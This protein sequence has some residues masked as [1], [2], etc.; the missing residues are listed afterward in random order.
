[1][2]TLYE[3]AFCTVVASSGRNPHD[4]MFTSRDPLRYSPCRIPVPRSGIWY[5]YRERDDGGPETA[6]ESHLNSRAWVYQEIILSRRMLYFTA[7]V[8][9]WSCRHGESC[10]RDSLGETCFDETIYISSGSAGYHASNLESAHQ[11]I[12][13]RQPPSGETVWGFG[14]GTKPWAGSIVNTQICRKF[15][16]DMHSIHA[17]PTLAQTESHE[18]NK[19]WFELVAEYTCRSLTVPG[20]KLIALSAIAT[21]LAKLWKYTHAA[22]LWK[23][24]LPHGLVWY[25]MY[26]HD[27]PQ[28]Y[29]ALS[30]SW[31]SIHG[32]VIFDDDSYNPTR[33][34]FL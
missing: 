20:D 13:G 5:A 34:A 7:F 17:I 21:K 8:V 31:A 29:I 30:F 16:N 15:L 11:G 32:E 28:N 33:T 10:E 24:T 1:M 9:F 27:R 3:N 23:E 2:G 12:E 22:G 25:V 6:R 14:S 18:R 19:E 4:G 26:A